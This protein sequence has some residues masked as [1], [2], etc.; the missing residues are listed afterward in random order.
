MENKKFNSKYASDPFQYSEEDLASI[1][2]VYV[3]P[4]K[5]PEDSPD[6]GF[7]EPIDSGMQQRGRNWFSRLTPVQKI[8]FLKEKKRRY[9][10]DVETSV[11]ADPDKPFT[12]KPQTFKSPG[13]AYNPFRGK[14]MGS[15]E[16]LKGPV[17]RGTERIRFIDKDDPKAKSL[18]N[19]SFR[20]KDT[21]EGQNAS[22]RHEMGA[23][24]AAIEVQHR[25]AFPCPTCGG[26]HNS[27][28]P[29]A[30]IGREEQQE[31]CPTCE[32]KGYKE[33]Q[34]TEGTGILSKMY[35]HH[36]GIKKW[37]EAVDWHEKNCKSY[38]CA[39]NCPLNVNGAIDKERYKVASQGLKLERKHSHARAGSNSNIIN[40]TAKRGIV[41]DYQDIART[42]ELIGGKEN[43][44]LRRGTPI[45]FVNHNTV[46]PDESIRSADIEHP[47][48]TYNPPSSLWSDTTPGTP[49]PP[50]P[51]EVVDP[52]TNKAKYPKGENDP[53]Y[54]R[55]ME[56]YKQNKFP[57]SS[58]YDGGKDNE[59]Y[60][61]KRAE[62]EERKR[63]ALEEHYKKFTKDRGMRNNRSMEQQY[64]VLPGEG[65]NQGMLLPS[66]QGKQMYGA[67]THVSSDGKRVRAVIKGENLNQI[68]SEYR[69]RTKGQFGER[70]Q[71]K[72]RPSAM[73]NNAKDPAE[74]TEQFK[75]RTTFQNTVKDTFTKHF[76][77]GRFGRRSPVRDSNWVVVEGPAHNFLR[78]SNATAPLTSYVGDIQT[79]VKGKPVIMSYYKS[80]GLSEEQ[81]KK[82]M[83]ETPSNLARQEMF[84]LARDLDRARGLN[85]NDEESLTPKF[86]GGTVDS[87]NE[88]RQRRGLSGASK[89]GFNVDPSVLS[90]SNDAIIP[91]AE[92]PGVLK[93][94]GGKTDKDIRTDLDMI[95]YRSVTER[96]KKLTTEE[97]K[98]AA[99]AIRKE[100][101][102]DGGMKALGFNTEEE[103]NE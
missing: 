101:H 54:I 18:L 61:T 16:R 56:I 65:R 28:N 43:Q 5:T 9:A 97:K 49:T 91:Q 11:I 83:I 75:L 7:T 40:L 37:N 48:E 41:S 90:Q 62:F 57:D 66:Y 38:G 53:L 82:G 93:K 26:K 102:I 50:N 29:I 47:H 79:N 78:I 42:F 2:G 84:N 87:I 27:G 44:P 15:M 74:S 58:E 88:D 3:P 71:V 8:N 20:D 51:N 39:H 35:D 21:L 73:F 1:P 30:P 77:K 12:R 33:P 80:H 60:K 99:E 76:D 19:P 63:I 86:D 13:F 64:N 55:D 31:Y 67:I 85:P 96:K 69:E 100:N 98:R 94:P 59:E 6:A 36:T 52:K 22:D 34:Y 24:L 23:A 4:A 70:K 103:E 92:S 32:N 45:M 17:V 68:R 46:D 72:F 81:F 25:L 14:G 10:P 95:N 89:G